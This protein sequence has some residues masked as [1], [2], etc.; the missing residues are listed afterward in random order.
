MFE[1]AEVFDLS[2]P[3]FEG[4]PVWATGPK[5]HIER[6][7][8]AA[9]DGVTG[10]EIKRMSMHTGTH[11]DAPAHF[12]PE[13]KWINDYPV[14]KYMGEGV[15]LD[16]RGIEPGK[17]ITADILAPFAD[18]IEP[19]DNVFCH[20]GWS[21]RRGL[22]PEYL[23]EFPY[24][25]EDAGEFFCEHRVNAVGVDTL[26]VGGFDEEVPNH[27]PVAETSAEVSHITLLEEDILPIEALN[28]VEK[29]LGD[30]ESQRAYFYFAPIHFREVEASPARVTAR[31]LE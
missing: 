31:V 8:W 13:G 19:G 20:T 23:F 24:L 25:T 15:A 18:D 6:M 14:E 28:N 21:E 11:V 4:M 3:V 2:T 1:N 7:A 9:A 5:P 30:T 29:L 22:T 17:P 12:I 26:S 27:G 10:T 16:L